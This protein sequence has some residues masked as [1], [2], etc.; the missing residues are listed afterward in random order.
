MSEPL[1]PC[2]FCGS[3]LEFLRRLKSDIEYL[4]RSY[5][6]SLYTSGAG[7]TLLPRFLEVKAL[8]SAM[9]QKGPQPEGAAR[10]TED[11]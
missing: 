8:L 5:G 6:S 3:V 10:V 1:K 9:E 7:Y 2:P 4:E 11:K